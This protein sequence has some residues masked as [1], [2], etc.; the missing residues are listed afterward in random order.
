M[1]PFGKVWKQNE[2]TVQNKVIGGENKQ[3]NSVDCSVLTIIS[4][5]T[6]LNKKGASQHG[7]R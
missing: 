5:G 4:A 2:L 1:L 6:V 7:S 3:A